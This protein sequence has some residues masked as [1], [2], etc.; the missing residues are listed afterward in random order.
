MLGIANTHAPY[1]FAAEITTP[2]PEFRD[3]CIVAVV[4]AHAGRPMHPHIMMVTPSATPCMQLLPRS[5]DSM[6]VTLPQPLAF[7]IMHPVLRGHCI[8][9][10]A[11]HAIMVH[12][13]HRGSFSGW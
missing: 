12:C 2:R 10:S 3:T 5:W 8:K 4:H 6:F 9:H 13:A 11:L 1:Y 7:T